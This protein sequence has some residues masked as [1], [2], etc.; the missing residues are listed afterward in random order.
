MRIGCQHVRLHVYVYRSPFSNQRQHRWTVIA[1]SFS[2]RMASAPLSM[3][4][5]CS[6]PL[7]GLISTTGGSETCWVCLPT[8][9]IDF[10]SPGVLR[11][12]WGRCRGNI[13]NSTAESS[14]FPESPPIR[15]EEFRNRGVRDYA[16]H[17]RRHAGSYLICRLV[18]AFRGMLA[19]AVQNR[20]MRTPCGLTFSRYL[21]D[22]SFKQVVACFITILVFQL[23]CASEALGGFASCRG[24]FACP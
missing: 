2:G 19:V 13:L 7:V 20:V 24:E 9:F 4:Q 12:P 10:G 5:R 11:K 14:S 18:Q 17:V 8:N 23:W 3:Y 6:I 1:D 21:N 22:R 16:T 15:A